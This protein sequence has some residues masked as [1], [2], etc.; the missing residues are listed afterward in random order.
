MRL[1]RRVAAGSVGG[2]AGPL[3]EVGALS[4]VGRDVE[5]PAHVG[6][7]PFQDGPMGR[8]VKLGSRP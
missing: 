7:V 3:E 4:L 8:R 6:T 1:G 2:L 5:D